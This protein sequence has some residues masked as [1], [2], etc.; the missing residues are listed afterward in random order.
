M[1]VKPYL[2]EMRGRG[3]PTLNPRSAVRSQG[4]PRAS[5]QFPGQRPQ[6][7]LTA[8]PSGDRDRGPC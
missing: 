3:T 7:Q 2:W 6:E 8:L 4:Q 5:P 1:R